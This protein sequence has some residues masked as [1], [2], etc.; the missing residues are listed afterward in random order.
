MWDEALDR[1]IRNHLRMLQTLGIPNSGDYYYID[2]Y[3]KTINLFFPLKR[4]LVYPVSIHISERQWSTPI[5]KANEHF[6]SCVNSQNRI[7]RKRGFKVKKSMVR[8]K[9]FFLVCKSYTKNVKGL[10]KHSYSGISVAALVIKVEEY[11]KEIYQRI[12]NYLS[13]RLTNLNYSF[14]NKGYEPFGVVKQLKSNLQH[15]VRFIELVCLA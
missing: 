6:Y 4:G 5:S 2:Y 1:F 3:R 10:I 8:D 13:K 12:L 7:L 9:T 15:Y 14:K 11:I